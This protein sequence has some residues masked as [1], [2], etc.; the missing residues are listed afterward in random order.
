MLQNEALTVGTRT[1]TTTPV[2]AKKRAKERKP[3]A[4]KSKAEKRALVQI[5]ADLEHYKISRDVRTE[6]GAPSVDIGDATAK[7]LRGCTLNEVYKVAAKEL[8][9]SEKSLRDRYTHLNV[10]QQRMTLGNRLRAVA[11]KEKK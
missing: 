7:R 11:K 8:D 1:D 3:R 4:K 2:A 10:G 9:A 6:S 5:K